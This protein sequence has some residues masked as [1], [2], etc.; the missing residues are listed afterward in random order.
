MK[1]I[2]GPARGL[3][4]QVMDKDARIKQ[5]KEKIDAFRTL[6]EDKDVFNNKP[7]I[8]MRLE[9][10]LL[11]Q[12]CHVDQDEHGLLVN[13]KFV[14]AVSKNKWCVKGKYVWYYYKDIP[15]FVAAYVKQQGTSLIRPPKR[16]QGVK[17]DS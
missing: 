9:I 2:Q 7:E 15:T 5:L 16:S 13:Q 11:E 14:V 6:T 4:G 10:E 8:R 17:V 3:K 1:L 12:G